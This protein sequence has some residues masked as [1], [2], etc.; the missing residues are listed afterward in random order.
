MPPDSSKTSP[1][2]AD[3]LT[4]ANAAALRLHTQ[5]LKI[6]STLLSLEQ[7]GRIKKLK[8]AQ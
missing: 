1:R 3:Y 8:T 2:V 5:G 6:E 7:Q 4:R